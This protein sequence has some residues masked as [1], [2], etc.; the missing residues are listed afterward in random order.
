MIYYKSVGDLG[1]IKPFSINLT[2]KNT[3]R[4][5]ILVCFVAGVWTMET[6]RKHRV[7]ESVTTT[8]APS[9]LSRSAERLTGKTWIPVVHESFWSD[10]VSGSNPQTTNR[11]IGRS[12]HY[13]ISPLRNVR[14][15][16]YVS[17]WY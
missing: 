15:M 1:G 12:D 10:P 11:E 3:G 7:I 8:T 5:L 16:A 4:D 2:G 14:I 13:A 9:T 6:R 17:A